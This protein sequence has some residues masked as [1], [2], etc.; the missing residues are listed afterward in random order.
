MIIKFMENTLRYILICCFAASFMAYGCTDKKPTDKSVAKTAVKTNA[1]KSDASAN[2]KKKKKVLFV[3]SYHKGSE[4]SDGIVEGALDV[5]GAKLLPDGK[6][7]NSGSK[8]ELKVF[9]MDTKRNKSVGFKQQAALEAKGIVDNWKPDVVITS[10]DNAAKYLIVP[11][12]KDSEIPFVFTGINLDAG[13]YGFPAKNITGIIEVAFVPEMVELLSKYAKGNRIGR[14]A[15]DAL[16]HRK[17]AKHYKDA[18]GVT[19]HEEVYVKTFDEWKAAFKDLQSK[20]DILFVNYHAG[21]DSWPEQEALEFTDEHTV[22]P[23][24]STL[25]WMI[26]HC[27]VS[28]AKMPQEHGEWAANAAMEILGGKSPAEVPVITNRKAGINLNMLLAKKLDITF[29]IELLEQATF[30]SERESK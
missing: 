6:V 29:P 7:D 4:W 21:L 27:L 15:P 30:A 20:V 17:A 9:Y 24:A 8:V 26:P 10:D 14:L 19:L 25:Q 3:N 23:T 5:F 16:T 13:I 28:Y 12:Y 11:Y 2:K 18:Y 22:I 1:E